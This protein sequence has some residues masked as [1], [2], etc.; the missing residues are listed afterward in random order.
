MLS[1]EALT[2]VIAALALLTAILVGYVNH[3][4]SEAAQDQAAA[5][6]QQVDLTRQQLNASEIARRES[7]EPYVVVDIA[8]KIG[9]PQALMLTIENIGPSVARNVRIA[10]EPP[11][12][13]SYEKAEGPATPIMSWPILVNGIATLPPGRRIELPFD[14]RGARVDGDLPMQYRITV[15]AD[16][17]FGPVSQMEYDIDLNIYDAEYLEEKGVAHLVKQLERVASF[18]EWYKR[19]EESEQFREWIAS[20]REKDGEP[21]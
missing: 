13:R 19:R 3:R 7:L 21:E 20:Q 16:G 2:F 14:M 8:P 6:T 9:S 18:V 10:S 5:A 4:A 12:Q 15:D 11:L 1:I 17:P